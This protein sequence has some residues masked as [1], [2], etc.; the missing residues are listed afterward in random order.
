[1]R[2]RIVLVGASGYGSSY[3]RELLGD[4][5]TG[6]DLVGVCDIRPDIAE[7]VPIL[8]ERN[9]PVYD[10]LEAF[11]A[12]QSADLAI[13]VSPVHFHTEMTLTCL[14]HGANVLCEKPLCLTVE[15]ARRMQEASR[16]AGKFLT[17]GYQLDYRRDVLALKKDILD[18][19]FGQPRRLS[20]YHC[21][22]RG[23]KYY[24]RNGWAGRISVN[25]REV[26]DSPF[27]N[28]CAHQFQMMT[29]LL[30]DTMASACDVTG[31]DAELYHGNPNVENYD[32]AAMR[33]HTD[34]GAPIFYYTAH[35]LKADLGP[36]GVFEFEKA[37]VYTEQ[38][39]PVIKA[40]LSDGTEIDYSRI[41]PGLPM[42]KLYDAIECARGGSA[43]LCGVEADL[44]HIKAVR[45]VQQQPILPVRDELR[46]VID[47]DG[48]AFTVIDGLEEA[49]VGSA[50]SWALPRE[51]GYRL[52]E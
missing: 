35:P 51:A 49:L 21:F 43:P 10:G 50:K 14:A 52:G 5:D 31:V 12:A 27:T 44:A 23:A 2:P 39:R 6:A 38:E 45:M 42:Q 47:M 34:K 37:T 40:V 15:E 20:I 17:L 3:L 36:V 24:A 1:M 4:K 11:F 29:F 7:R 28:A 8:K 16:A 33:F 26:F 30:G 13:I 9:I 48:D 41:D 18:G 46:H 19:R 22:H 25:G 32:I